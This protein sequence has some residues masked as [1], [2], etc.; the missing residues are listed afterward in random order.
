[1]TSY[2]VGGITSYGTTGVTSNYGTTG[3]TGTEYGASTL[4]GS[5]VTDTPTTYDRKSNLGGSGVS[6]SGYS[7]QTKKYWVAVIILHCKFIHNH[8]LSFIT[9][10]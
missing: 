1:L 5:K 8:S 9:L 3:F 6:G 4:T 7:Y 10:I 2:G